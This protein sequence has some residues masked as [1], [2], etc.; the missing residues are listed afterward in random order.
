MELYIDSTSVI[1]S[2][3][4]PKYWRLVLIQSCV[5]AS[6]TANLHT[7]LYLQWMSDIKNRIC[8]L[9]QDAEGFY[10]ACSVKRQLTEIIMR[11]SGRGGV[12]R[13]NEMHKG[14]DMQQVVYLEERC[15][16]P[17]LVINTP[18]FA[19]GHY[20]T[21]HVWGH[22]RLPKEGRLLLHRPRLQNS[23]WA[24]RMPITTQLSHQRMNLSQPIEVNELTYRKANSIS[25][26]QHFWMIKHSKQD[27][28]AG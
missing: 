23:H 22:H 28:H 26:P 8:I 16:R 4:I 17:T 18:G 9:K 1:S 13:A 21:L 19:N 6:P 20:D 10:K 14:C 5:S 15:F 27:H 2:V 24:V 12:V 7:L 3:S 11:C 25:C